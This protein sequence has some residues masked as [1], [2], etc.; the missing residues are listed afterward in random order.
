MV[1]RSV[2]QMWLEIPVV[3]EV[4]YRAEIPSGVCK[5]YSAEMGYSLSPEKMPMDGGSSLWNHLVQIK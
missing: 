1:V 4:S 3:K 5:R 2:Y